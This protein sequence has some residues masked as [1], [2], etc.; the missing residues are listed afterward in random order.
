MNKDLEQRIEEAIESC[1]KEGID[2]RDNGYGCKIVVAKGS[3]TLAA[4][5]PHNALRLI[6]IAE[7]R[8]R[9]IP[10]EGVRLS[11]LGSDIDAAERMDWYTVECPD[12]CSF[13]VAHAF[14]LD[15]DHGAKSC[16]LSKIPEYLLQYKKEQE[17]FVAA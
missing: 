2:F 6:Q 12:G 8:Y 16:D 14:I 1:K 9:Y 17:D 10:L 3:H 11:F 7:D 15:E 13:A 4:M 5:N